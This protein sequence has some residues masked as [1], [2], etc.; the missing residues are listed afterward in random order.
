MVDRDAAAAAAV[1]E[2]IGSDRAL[3][4]TADVTSQ[5]ETRAMAGTI[6]ERFG[7]IDVLVNNAGVRF[8]APFA[9]MSLETWRP[10]SM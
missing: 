1:A 2:A 3:A 7:R 10:P 4:V 8:I 5:D 9:E 6:A